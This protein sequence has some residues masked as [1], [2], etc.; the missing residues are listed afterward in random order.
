MS[1]RVGTEPRSQPMISTNKT[2][3]TFRLFPA[4]R[5]LPEGKVPSCEHVIEG[6]ASLPEQIISVHKRCAAGREDSRRRDQSV[7]EAQS[8]SLKRTS[9]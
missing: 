5:L 3:G 9:E 1:S 8:I 6:A 4:R 2:F 7:H